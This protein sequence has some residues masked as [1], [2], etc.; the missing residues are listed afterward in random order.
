ME[1]IK[2]EVSV[3]IDYIKGDKR[4]KER[5]IKLSKD[6]ILSGIVYGMEFSNPYKAKLIK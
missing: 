4:S 2:F 5:A 3:K 1:I 6:L